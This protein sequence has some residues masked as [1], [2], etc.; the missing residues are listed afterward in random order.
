[1]WV[2]PSHG[3]AGHILDL[4]SRWASLLKRAKIEN[5]RIHDLRRTQGSWQAAAGASLSI[6]GKS[7]GH[8]STAATA[9]YAR[10]DLDPVRQSMTAVNAAM[11]AAMKIK[12]KQL[13]APR[14]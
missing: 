5:F 3:P 7:L 6:I 1:M 8:S 4:K 13:R 11:L 12:P 9:V 2:F 14:S 10:L